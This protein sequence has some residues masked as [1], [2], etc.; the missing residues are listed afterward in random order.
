MATHTYTN[1]HPRYLRRHVSTYWWMER[2]S[3]F[4]FILREAS[5][6]FVAWFVVYLLMLVNA[7]ASGAADYQ[8]FLAW[9]ATPVVLTVNVVAFLFMVFHAITFFDAAPQAMVMHVGPKKVPGGLVLAGHYAGWLGLSAVIAW[10]LVGT[11]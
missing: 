10:L 11:R 5:C 9:S 1:Y 2:G 4:A 7:V 8:Q 3:Y 6:V